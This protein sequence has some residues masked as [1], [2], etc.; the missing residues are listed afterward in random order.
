MYRYVERVSGVSVGNFI[1]FWKSKWL[2]GEII[3]APGTRDYSLNPQLNYLG[4]NTRL[5]FKESCLKQDKDFFSNPSV[6]TVI[7]LGVDM[8]SFTEIENMKKD[9]LILGKGPTQR[10]EHM[11]SVEKIYSI[12]FTKNNKKFC[13]SLHYIIKQLTIYLSMV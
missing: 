3:T 8:N 10:L 12:T 9:I 2:S 7:I 5:E 11:L 6:E 13:L 1:Y 4:I